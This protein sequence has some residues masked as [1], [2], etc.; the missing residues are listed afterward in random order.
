MAARRQLLTLLPIVFVVLGFL[1]TT[2][3]LPSCCTG[4]LNSDERFAREFDFTRPVQHTPQFGIPVSFPAW[5]AECDKPA[6]LDY[7]DFYAR[8]FFAGYPWAR[9]GLDLTRFTVWIHDSLGGFAAGGVADPTWARGWLVGKYSIV[10]W[11][12]AVKDGKPDGPATRDI[13]PA[14]VHEWFHA[15]FQ[16]RYGCGDAGHF[17]WFPSPEVQKC[18]MSATFHALARSPI[19]LSEET[20]RGAK[21]SLY[22]PWIFPNSYQ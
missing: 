15:A 10:A 2:M 3:L 4:P 18:M 17:L 16:A 8:E 5:L 7:I 9:K 19:R 13:L 11:N 14:V 1:G 6:V 12:F 20:M 21:Q 22:S